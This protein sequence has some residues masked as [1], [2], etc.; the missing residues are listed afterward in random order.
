MIVVADTTPLHYLV[1]IEEVHLLP[2][3]YGGVLIPPA[4]LA[5]LSDP[6]A[7][8]KVR[9]WIE[10]RPEWLQVRV[11]A[12]LPPDLPATLGPGECEAIALSEEFGADALLID[13]WDGRQEAVRRRLTV[14]A[15][16]GCWVAPRKKVWLT[17]RMLSGCCA[18]Q[19]FASAQISLNG[20]S[21]RTEGENHGSSSPARTPGS[22]GVWV[23]TIAE[24][25]LC[26]RPA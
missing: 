24:L 10:Y 22:R 20:C 17:C 8:G 12:H 14:M 9:R 16:C 11:P 6:Q 18:Q 15:R 7:P 23:P 1:I 21:N 4:V 3:L 5:E 25:A 19:T 2:A 26:G 13:E